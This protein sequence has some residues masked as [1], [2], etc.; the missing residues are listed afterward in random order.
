MTD[1]YIQLRKVEFT[2]P[3]KSVDIELFPGVNVI[4]GASDTGKSFLAETIDFMLGGTSLKEIPERVG[5]GTIGLML[6]TTEDQKWQ[7]ERAISGGDFNLTNL[8][9]NSD[10]EPIKLGQKHVHNRIDNLSGFLLD[11]IGLLGKRILK[12][13]VKGTTQNLSFR[14]LA[15]L[16]IVQESEIQQSGSPFWG[17]QYTQK[18]SEL[19]TVKLMLTGVDD[20]AVISAPLEFEADNTKQIALID[21]LLSELTDDI[22]DLGQ[23]EGELTDQLSRLESSLNVRR[24]NLAVVQRHLDNRIISRQNVFADRTAIKERLDEISEHLERF[25]LLSKHYEIDKERLK[26]IQESGSIFTHVDKVRCPLCGAEPDDQHAVESCDGDVEAAVQAAS[27][28]LDKIDRLTVELLETVKDLKQEASE[29]SKRFTAKT[30][31]YKQ[32]DLEIRETISPQVSEVRG[33]FSELIDEQVNVQKTIDLFERI[34]KLEDRKQSLIDEDKEP[35]SKTKI[36][37]GLPDSVSHALSLKIEAILTAWNFPGECRVH[38]D[39]ESSDFVIDGKPRGSRGKGLRA[40]TH[41]AVTLGLLEYCQEHSL[42]HPGF[43]VLD[44]P[45]LAYFKPEGD[46]DRNLQGTDLKERFYDYLIQH[47]RQKSQVIIIENL[48][49]PA[50]VENDLS[51]TIFTRNPNEGRFGLL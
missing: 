25:K 17:G 36:S 51:M 6:T 42:P 1:N 48:H 24:Q 5:Y 46:D 45:L 41:A 30:D 39:K 11:K 2:G 43:V 12:S 18:T 50:E 37:T 16:V 38:F 14:N 31:E 34:T 47:H 7:L 4:C 13:S 29:L 10:S 21:E 32:L 9:T 26:S 19:A 40:I 23:E 44:S 28:E 22:G 3:E 35:S 33:E 20:S 49:P 8:D 27:A 15:R